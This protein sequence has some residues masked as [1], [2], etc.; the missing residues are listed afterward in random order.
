[1]KNPDDNLTVR[2]PMIYDA[3]CTHS[4]CKHPSIGAGVRFN[5]KKKTIGTFLDSVKIYEF[6]MKCPSCKNDFVIR[7]DPKK[8]DYIFV[9]GIK[10]LY[11]EYYSEKK[12]EKAKMMEKAASREN[13]SLNDKV[14]LMDNEI[15]F[16]KRTAI[17]YAHIDI[18]SKS[19]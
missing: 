10:K 7:T 8:A 1:M 3:K 18:G 2:F 14:K 4:G 5:A 16:N 6:T 11:S 15:N 9:S 19:I 12:I 13:L 17:R